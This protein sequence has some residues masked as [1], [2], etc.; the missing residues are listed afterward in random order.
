MRESGCC[1]LTHTEPFQI[2]CNHSLASHVNT[3]RLFVVCRFSL[4]VMTIYIQ[5]YRNFSCRIVRDVQ[6]CGNPQI[7]QYFQT[8][9]LN[10][11]PRSALDQIQLLN[12]CPCLL[13]FSRFSSKHDSLER[14][15]P[16]S[17]R[18]VIPFG[19]RFKDRHIRDSGGSETSHFLQSLLFGNNGLRQRCRQLCRPFVCPTIGVSRCQQQQYE[20]HGP[21]QHYQSVAVYDH[22]L[23]S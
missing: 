16:R 1:Q 8:Q 23:D 21:D 22:G 5:K 20:Q 10:L 2:Q 13:P 19:D 3:T 17:R 9:L 15:S 4:A 6:Q 11:I 12:F 18:I 7:R 14:R